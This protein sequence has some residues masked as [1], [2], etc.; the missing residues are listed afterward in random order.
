MLFV[1]TANRARSPLAEAMLRRLATERTAPILVSSAGFLDAGL[2]A[3]PEMVHAAAE[4]GLDLRHHRSRTVDPAMVRDADV[5]VCMEAGH[6]LHLVGLAPERAARVFRL[7][8]L[9]GLART[10]PPARQLGRAGLLTWLDHLPARD[11]NAALATDLDTPD[12]AGGGRRRFRR[13]A[14]ELAGELAA[15]AGAWFGPVGPEP[16]PR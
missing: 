12:P 5:V 2:P 3:L 15:L 4:L 10:I 8:E 13:C 9:A 7:R 16:Q 11:L 14:A 1:C 6:L